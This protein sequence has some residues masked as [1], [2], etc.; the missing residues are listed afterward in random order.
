MAESASTS[1]QTTPSEALFENVIIGPSPLVRAVWLLRRAFVAAYEDNCFGIAKG[2]AYSFLLSLF[3]I[4]TTLTSILIQ[5]RAQAVVHVIA[6]FLMQVVPPGTEELILS[7]LREKGGPSG[8]LPVVAVIVSLWAGSGAMMS[9]MEG[10][11]AAYRI[12]T[13]R[14]FLKERGMG[15]LLVLIAALPAVGASSLIIMGDR[16]ASAFIHWIGSPRVSEISTPVLMLWGIARYGVAFCT[17]A[18]V[19]GLLYY[20]GPNYV[21]EPPTI[22]GPPPSRFLRVWPGAFIATVLWLP[23]TVGFAWYVAHIANYNF[24]YGSLGTVII[25]L[26]WLY[27]TACIT[28]VGCEFNAERD[29]IEAMPSLY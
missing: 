2:A 8:S 15:I 10:F 4:L 12:P 5:V 7:R 16:G 21:P 20:F 9:L 14:P 1:P 18:F 25:L 23:A 22:K 28:L 17:T 26:V 13:G 11:R 29:R 19:T 3:P 24:F 27:L 6:T